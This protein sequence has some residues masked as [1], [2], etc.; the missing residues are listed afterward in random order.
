VLRERLVSGRIGIAEARAAVAACAEGY[1]FP[2]NLDRD[3]P[4]GGLAPG[5]Q[6][7]LMLRALGENWAPERFAQA[8]GEHG[9]RRD[10]AD[11]AGTGAR[12]SAQ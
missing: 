7:A 4:V 8:L 6:Q 5:S 9:A 10:P 1:P 12:L 3:P 2:T 11:K